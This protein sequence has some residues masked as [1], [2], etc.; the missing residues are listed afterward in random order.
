MTIHSA[1]ERLAKVWRYLWLYGPARTRAKI[2]AAFHMK[3]RFDRIPPSHPPRAGQHVGIIGCGTYAYAIIAW[4]L[5]RLRGPVIRTVMDVDVHRAASLG[6]RY[7]AAVWTNDAR[8]VIDDPEIDLVFIASDHASHAPYAVEALA[9]GK[10]VHLEKPHVVNAAQLD[11]LCEALQRSSSR[12]HIGFNRP[13]APL[14]H[15]LERAVRAEAGPTTVSCFVVGHVLEQSH[16]YLDP[17]QGGR[18][19]GNLC[20]W[21]DLIERLCP[22]ENRRPVLLR[23]LPSTDPTRQLGVGIGY[24]DVSASVTMSALGPTFEGVRESLRLQR[25]RLI[26]ALDDFQTLRLDHDT[27]TRRAVSR[28]RDAGHS[29]M[30]GCSLDMARRGG[31]SGDSIQE[32]VESGRLMLAT[33][34]ALDTQRDVWLQAWDDT[35]PPSE[36]LT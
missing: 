3:R 10:H 36:G 8:R 33:Q 1:R 16:W 25:G 2:E 22:A 24:E 12:L 20:H 23:P 30:I 19:L 14:F 4:N 7:G 9:R 6:T 11:A 26:A 17:R 29:A 15:T 32:V 28:L 18:S 21:T 34:R 13:H 27:A 31:F 5:W 35:R